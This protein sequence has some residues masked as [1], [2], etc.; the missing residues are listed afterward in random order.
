[1]RINTADIRAC[2]IVV[3]LSILAVTT[4][5]RSHAD[6]ADLVVCVE[7]SLPV[8][9]EPCRVW[10]SSQDSSEPLQLENMTVRFHIERSDGGQK[11]ID[12]PVNE[13]NDKPGSRVSWTPDEPGRFRITASVQSQLAS[14]TVSAANV[15]V[16]SRKLHFNYWQTRPAQRFVTSVM[17]NHETNDSAIRWK[18]RGALP[19][20]HKSGQWHWAHGYDSK[21]KMAKLWVNLP[22]QRSGIVID[23]FGGGDAIDQQLG[24]A[25]LLT[26]KQRP[27]M[28]IAPYCLSVSGPKMIHGYRH[29]DLILVET[30]TADWRWDGFIT[31][32]W[33]TAMDAGL[34]KK[35]IAVLGLGSQ[36]IGT[37][38][39]LRRVCRMI[40]TTCPEMPGIGFFP[41][42][43]PRLMKA[44]DSAIE[45]YFLR[46]VV[47]ASVHG[48]HSVIRNIGESSAT[49]VEFVFL[50]SQGREVATRVIPRVRP[51]NEKKVRL[52]PNAVNV[53]VRRAP[54]RY[55][56]LS[57]IPTVQERVPGED[58]QRAAL[59]V[60]EQ[61]KTT[62]ASDPLKRVDE[63]ILQ[64]T[65]QANEDPDQHNNVRSGTIP[66]GSS[67]GRAVVLSFD[68]CPNRCWFYG[69]NSISLVG[70]GELTLTWARQDHDAGLE[71]NQPRP[72]LIFKGKD[73]YVVREV[74][75]IGFRE[76]ESC[77]AVL[78]YD[79]R[80]SVRALVFDR[81]KQL[82]WDSGRLPAKGGF[83]CRQLRFDVNPY[84]QSEISVDTKDSSVVMKGGGGGED[85]PYWLKSTLSHL[86]LSYPEEQHE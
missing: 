51:W 81:R 5:S 55:T 79:G 68:I 83:T 24:E 12:L 48:S 7:H 37:E 77:H 22:Q 46:P 41:D 30:Y 86:R 2:L 35:S 54:D 65:D 73:K 78:A 40:R 36:W 9:G 58:E 47:E 16:T 29:A 61:I 32:R 52:P 39:E 76:N 43:P 63:M 80:E 57:Y 42:V 66:I 28:F 15:W 45:D 13:S 56:L 11:R 38:R 71:A 26:R 33:K 34:E 62:A 6:D 70:D 72:A 67:K 21:E 1:M 31:G 84:P 49:N 17:D 25:L 4:V 53:Q 10:L 50:D 60:L 20:G 19:L 44:V 82:L 8:A 75:G 23:E 3:L 18:Q 14:I 59:R 64:R 27:E 85:S 69:H 74:S